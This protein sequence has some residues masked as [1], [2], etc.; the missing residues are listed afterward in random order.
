MGGREGGWR[1]GTSWRKNLK[2]AVPQTHIEDAVQGK[3]GLKLNV[4]ESDENE[5]LATWN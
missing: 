5:V 2:T 3:H 1:L 4:A